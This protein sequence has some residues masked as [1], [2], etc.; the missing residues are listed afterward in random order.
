[1]FSNEVLV[2]KE[3][4]E[5]LVFLLEEANNILQKYP[6]SSCQGSTVT[7]MS[8]AKNAVKE[9]KQWCGY[10]EVENKS[11][12]L[13][14]RISDAERMKKPSEAIKNQKDIDER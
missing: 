12:T 3:D 10:L 14:E 11:F 4:K 1:M 2:A 13:A 8:R 6:F 5:R 9:A 7:T